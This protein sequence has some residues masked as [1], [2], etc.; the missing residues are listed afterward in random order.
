MSILKVV[1][2]PPYTLGAVDTIQIVLLKSADPVP[3][4]LGQENI[5]QT[6]GAARIVIP[7]GTT[8]L[9]ENGNEAVGDVNVILNFINPSEDTFEDF[10]GRFVTDSRDELKSFGVLN[11]RFTNNAGNSLTPNGNIRIALDSIEPGYKLWLLNGAGEWVEKSSSA[12]P[13]I[14]TPSLLEFRV[15]LE[16]KDNPAPPT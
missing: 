3:V 11:L 4:A 1:D 5:L 16:L 9:D 10:P 13:V 14:G 8:F 6:R 12:G 7:A 15:N 2:K